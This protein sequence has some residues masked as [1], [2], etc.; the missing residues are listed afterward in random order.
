VLISYYDDKGHCRDEDDN[1]LQPNW[2]NDF[3]ELAREFPHAY[4]GFGERA[5]QCQDGENAQTCLTRKVAYIKTVYK[6]WVD[7]PKY[8]GGYF[9]WYFKED[10]IP[11]TNELWRALSE[12]IKQGPRPTL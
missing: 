11:S 5:T 8:I 6:L 7:H 4:I 10:M 3:L 2:Q 12:A 9:W 1:P